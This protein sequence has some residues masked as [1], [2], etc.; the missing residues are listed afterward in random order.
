[1]QRYLGMVTLSSEYATLLSELRGIH[2]TPGVQLMLQDL[3]ANNV[4]VDDDAPGG[5]IRLLLSDPAMALRI[6]TLRQAKPP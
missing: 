1:M 5:G 2:T 4:L 3:T 6:S